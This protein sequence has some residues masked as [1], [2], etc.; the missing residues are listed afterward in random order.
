MNSCV[1]PSFWKLYRQ[2]PA[3]LRQRARKAYRLWQL[4]PAHPSLAFK[5]ISASGNLYSVRITL[6]FRV[7]ARLEGRD[8][9]ETFVWFF[10][11]THDDY[12][13]EIAKR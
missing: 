7:L 11:G 13:R 1:E 2:L 9:N 6:G 3:E 8:G 4:D 10:I 5:R 12:M